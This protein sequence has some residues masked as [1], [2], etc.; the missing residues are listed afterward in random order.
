MEFEYL[1]DKKEMIPSLA[2]WYFEEWGNQENGRT[3]DME[4]EGLQH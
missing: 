3:I 2:N 1:A 4:I